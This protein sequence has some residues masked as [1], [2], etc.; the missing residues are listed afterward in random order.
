MAVV[1]FLL[2]KGEIITGTNGKA[3][4]VHRSGLMAHLMEDTPGRAAT[5]GTAGAFTNLTQAHL[6]FY[7][8]YHLL[9][10][11]LACSGLKTKLFSKTLSTATAVGNSDDDSDRGVPPRARARVISYGTRPEVELNSTNKPWSFTEVAYTRTPDAPWQTLHSA[12]EWS[13]GM[14]VANPYHSLEDR[15]VASQSARAG[16]TSVFGCG[17]DRDRN[18]RPLMGETYWQFVSR[19]CVSGEYNHSLRRDATP[20]TVEVY[21]PA[22]GMWIAARTAPSCDNS[23]WAWFATTVNGKVYC[24]GSH[25][26]WGSTPHS[27]GTVANTR[28]CR[29]ET[30]T[31]RGERYARRVNYGLEPELT[32]S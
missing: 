5:E 20:N 29:I 19:M 8:P 27:F 24:V 11:P 6:F 23:A 26:Q 21:D 9:G 15:E 7:H 17:G 2:K 28:M 22:Y 32:M 1:A 13:S 16:A 12:R 25:L 18:K 30:P 3:K 14:M 4:T 10:K 31:A